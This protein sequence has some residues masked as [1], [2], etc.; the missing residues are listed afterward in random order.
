MQ[1][2]DD[3]ARSNRS[4]W[5]K[6]FIV[7]SALAVL[8]ILFYAEEDLRGKHAWENYKREWQATGEK[9]DLA[10]FIPPPVPD[11]QNFAMTPIVASGY[12]SILDKNG[13]EHPYDSNVVNRLSMRIYRKDNWA[14]PTNG[15]WT[16]GTFI[17]LQAWQ[18]YYRA[19]VQ[20]NQ[21]LPVATNEFPVARDWQSP[22]EDVLLALSRNDSN[23]EELRRASGLPDS[24]FPLEYDKEDPAAIFLPHLSGLKGASLALQLRA[25]AELQ[26]GETDK[27]ATDIKLMLR[28]AD[29]PRNEPF[30]ISHLV[31]I[32][33][34]N[35][36]LQPIYEGLAAREWSDAQLTALDSELAK[37][38]FLA[39]YQRSMR[40]EAAYTIKMIDYI[41]RTHKISDYLNML[42]F[43]QQP[44]GRGWDY[45]CLAAPSGWYYRN[46]L[47]FSRFYLQQ[48]L[49]L[50]N[51]ESREVSPK[52][53]D[54][55]E[56]RVAAMIAHPNPYNA[57]QCV[58]LSHF[59]KL[60]NPAIQKYFSVKKFAFGQESVDLARVAIALERYRLVHNRYPESLDVLSPRFMAKV[61]RDIIDGG[62]LKY[63][64]TNGN[65][66]LYSIGWN[67]TDDGGTYGSPDS[68]S[69]DWVWQYPSG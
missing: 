53:I 28:L 63:R 69:G 22:V 11:D 39:D 32:A 54:Q 50:V 67:E 37:L 19:P 36:S 38:D 35:I 3:P 7:I 57:L 17:D 59:G 42:N 34:V 41:Q 64:R 47:G 4:I 10:G 1:T 45:V 14:E 58:F 12:E 13:H 62:A 44:V 2:M 40:S 30:Q 16:K 25:V 55:A 29:S 33:I 23:I 24:R 21:E 43:D 61:P 65:F 68:D 5:R 9:F 27:A 60:F 51:L 52:A 6:L 8:V 31:R 15:D 56:A 48:A 66:T 18:A 26:K 20:T 46:Q 49:P